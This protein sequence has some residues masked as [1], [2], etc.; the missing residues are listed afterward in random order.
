MSAPSYKSIWGVNFQNVV[1]AQNGPMGPPSFSLAPSGDQ[2]NW[3]Q[4]LNATPYVSTAI[5][6][7]PSIQSSS[8]IT[9]TPT[10]YS[11]VVHGSTPLGFTG[12]QPVGL[13]DDRVCKTESKFF[14]I[15]TDGAGVTGP[16]GALTMETITLTDAS[17]NATITND[18]QITKIINQTTTSGYLTK[19]NSGGND[20]MCS[21][22]AG[23]TTG[24]GSGFCTNIQVTRSP[25]YFYDGPFATKVG[26]F[27]D[28]SN[29]PNSPVSGVGSEI[30]SS[31]TCC[32]S[33]PGGKIVWA[34]LTQPNSVFSSTTNL[35][36][37]PIGTSPRGTFYDYSSS[38]PFI[39]SSTVC[40]SGPSFNQINVYN[41]SSS[42]TPGTTG[43]SCPMKG[44]T[45]GGP[46][47]LSK[48]DSSGNVLWFGRIG[49]DSGITG[50]A[51]TNGVNL[52]FGPSNSSINT[53][54]FIPNDGI[55][56]T[57]PYN[58]G[59]ATNAGIGVWSA[60][61]GLGPSGDPSFYSIIPNNNVTG[62]LNNSY[63]AK[64]D[65]SGNAKFLT[66][67][68]G[69]GDSPANINT[70][71]FLS[72][73]ICSDS[74]SSIY[75]SG[76]A[77]NSAIGFWNPVAAYPSLARPTINYFITGIPGAGTATGNCAGFV[78]KYDTSGTPLR[79]SILT[80]FG[81]AN[82][83]FLPYITGTSFYNDNLYV[84]G[85][86]YGNLAVSGPTGYQG[87]IGNPG[88][89]ALTCNITFPP[90][91]YS[92]TPGSVPGSFIVKYNSSLQP[93]WIAKIIKPNSSITCFRTA[94][95]SH[96]V[97][98]SGTYNA[99]GTLDFYNGPTGLNLGL[100]C[101]TPSYTTSNN[102]LNNASYYL[103]K[104]D[105]SGNVAWAITVNGTDAN[106]NPNPLLQFSSLSTDDV[107]VYYSFTF[108]S[109]GNGNNIAPITIYDSSGGIIARFLLATTP[110]TAYDG[111]IIR[112]LPN[113]KLYPSINLT[114]SNPSNSPM[115]KTI[116]YQ[117]DTG[118]LG[119]TP[120]NTMS[121]ATFNEVNSFA[122]MGNNSA[123][124][125]LYDSGSGY[126][127]P[128]SGTWTVQS[129]NGYVLTN[130]PIL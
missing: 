55:Y 22:S 42:G 64:F 23:G 27:L 100:R 17:S 3:T 113:G 28:N 57:N 49:S 81:Y 103:C 87:Y 90:N 85:I 111:F 102:A 128:S 39:Y 44:S 67:I 58:A 76:I 26:L 122:A 107:S 88:A 54:A 73:S 124:N 74:S 16:S 109:S 83:T 60:P 63:V 46:M 53:L 11:T 35:I 65:P 68:G 47:I 115:N 127:Q 48:Y 95:A 105:F 29:I 70:R 106:N 78:T 32:Y 40:S 123:M 112:V 121:D 8:P 99:T 18:Y 25:V 52:V 66:F 1:N 51:A 21:M 92:I 20:T 2:I 56:I 79:T 125:L 110:T 129:N 7:Q 80:Q 94:V 71:N 119:I 9:Y 96:G 118:L 13:F 10:T 101:F 77:T 98:A 43:L 117:S 108:S 37:Y 130:N 61:S 4:P 62:M 116:I 5:A 114:A 34:A 59:S 120:T 38:K 75:I 89:T 50:A 19:F 24:S 72:T 86:S 104:Y 15:F 12:S 14:P 41:G 45:S 97:Y 84:T 31:L 126:P 33:N 6:S 69:T 93:Q 30:F 36:T 91:G 82:N